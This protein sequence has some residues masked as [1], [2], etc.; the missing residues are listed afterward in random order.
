MIVGGDVHRGVTVVAEVSKM[1]MGHSPL[2][3]AVDSTA[4]EVAEFLVG[5]RGGHCRRRGRGG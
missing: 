4:V 1:R 3:R 5:K 2:G